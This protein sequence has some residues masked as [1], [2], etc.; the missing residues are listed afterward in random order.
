MWDLIWLSKHGAGSEEGRIGR[1][2]CAFVGEVRRVVY[3][4][5]EGSKAGGGGRDGE[6][7]RGIRRMS[8]DRRGQSIREPFIMPFCTKMRFAVTPVCPEF[9]NLARI[10][11]STAVS[12]FASSR[13]MKGPFPRGSSDGF[14]KLL[15]H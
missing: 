4:V 12:S 14:I 15:P 1:F 9:L 7:E 13:T 8:L 6:E 3:V 2:V 11:A 5:V 10:H